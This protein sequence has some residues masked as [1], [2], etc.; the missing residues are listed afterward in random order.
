[1]LPPPSTSDE[2]VTKW[3]ILDVLEESALDSG[4]WTTSGLLIFITSCSEPYIN[5]HPHFVLILSIITMLA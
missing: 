3:R 4:H 5:S 2:T 1:M